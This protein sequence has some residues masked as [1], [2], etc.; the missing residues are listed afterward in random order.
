MFDVGFAGVSLVFGEFESC[1]KDRKST[2]KKS[3]RFGAALDG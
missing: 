2:I 3:E 1:D